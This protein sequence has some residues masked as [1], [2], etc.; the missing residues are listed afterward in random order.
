VS[1]TDKFRQIVAAHAAPMRRLCAVYAREPA[2]RDD[3]FQDIFLAVWRALPAFR[4]EAS[5]RTW[6]Y[7][8]AHNTAITWQGRDR[9]TRDRRS[10]L[11]EARLHATDPPDERRAVLFDMISQLQPIDRQLISLSLEGLSME[12]IEGV[13]GMRAGTVAVRLTRIR[14]LLAER[15]GNTGVTNG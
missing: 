3:L 2:D 1:N 12:E 9:R 11:D 4:A 6:L 14:R 8:I 10:D 13:T 7:R 15:V 5:K